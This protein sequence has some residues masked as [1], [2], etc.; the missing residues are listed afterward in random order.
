[1]EQS[2]VFLLSPIFVFTMVLD[3]IVTLGFLNPKFF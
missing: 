2:E 1:M 3:F